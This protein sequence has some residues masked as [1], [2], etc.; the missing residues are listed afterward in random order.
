MR[1]HCDEMKMF[2]NLPGEILNKIFE[3]LR[4]QDIKRLSE[5]CKK[6]QR[7]LEYPGHW[8]HVKIRYLQRQILSDRTK[9][10]SED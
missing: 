10:P 5:T 1:H 3:Y 4:L 2:Y 7:V 8:K 9:I 6:F